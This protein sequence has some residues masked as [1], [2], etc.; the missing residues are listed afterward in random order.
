MSKSDALKQKIFEAI[1]HASMCWE[2][3]PKGVFDSTEAGKV[4]EQLLKDVF[5]LTL[6]DAPQDAVGLLTQQLALPPHKRD[7]NVVYDARNILITTTPEATPTQEA[8]PQ[9]PKGR[10]EA[11]CSTC[12]NFS[13]GFVCQECIHDPMIAQDRRNLYSPKPTEPPTEGE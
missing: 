4:G 2:P 1:G 5:V 13:D 10:P 8:T 7:W 11:D 3:R 12:A 6:A 9:P